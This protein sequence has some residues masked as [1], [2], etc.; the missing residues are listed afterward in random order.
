MVARVVWT[1][2][3]AGGLIAGRV[4]LHN[5]GATKRECL[6][7]LPGDEQVADPA[8]VVTRAVTVQAAAADVWPWLV[9]IGQDRAGFYSYQWLENLFGLDIHNADVI[10]PEW[11]QL[12]VGDRIRLVPPGWFKLPDGVTMRVSRIDPGHSLVLF[13][14]PWPVVWSFHVVPVRP[15]RCRLIARSRSP[16]TFGLVRLGELLYDPITFVMTRKMLIGIRD[17]AERSPAPDFDVS[18]PRPTETVAQ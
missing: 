18:A 16:K 1:G 10:R 17:R 2:V 6:T 7:V 3:A 8:T 15:L 5:W 14:D 12:A 4:V 13:G 9:Q 11:Q